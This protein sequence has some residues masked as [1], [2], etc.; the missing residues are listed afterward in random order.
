MRVRD[1]C[2]SADL[3]RAAYP[4][5]PHAEPPGPRRL[6]EC[7]AHDLVRADHFPCAEAP[8]TSTQSPAAATANG[9]TVTSTTA[10][11]GETHTH[12]QWLNWAETSIA[13]LTALYEALD[14]MCAQI[15]ADDGD[16]AQAAALR[17]WQAQIGDTAE[18]GRRMVDAVNAAQ[19]PVG[20][21]V[22]A[23]G[24]SAATPHKQYAD[25]ARAS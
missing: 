5:W 7:P 12:R 21:A 18:A 14:G 10:D 13:G 16:Q 20:D 19:V 17:T 3:F 8:G 4:H 2:G 22:A 15:G 1:I 24:G 23:A 6:Y 11:T 9:G 25:E